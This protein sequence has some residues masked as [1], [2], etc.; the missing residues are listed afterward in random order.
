M[1]EK[2]LASRTGEI[3]GQ[4]REETGFNRYSVGFRE[5]RE[6]LLK[7][8]EERSNWLLWPFRVYEDPPPEK[9]DGVYE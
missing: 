1:D 7:D 4:Y 2:A 5:G 3:R 9:D 8:R 6:P